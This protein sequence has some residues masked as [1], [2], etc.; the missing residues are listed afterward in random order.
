MEKLAFIGFEKNF[1][2]DLSMAEMIKMEVKKIGANPFF[3]AFAY[4]LVIGVALIFL[5]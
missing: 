2:G 1:A 4:L 5:F 3:P